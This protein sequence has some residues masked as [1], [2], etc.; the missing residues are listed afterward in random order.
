MFTPRTP[1]ILMLKRP[2]ESNHVQIAVRRRISLVRIAVALLALASPAATQLK[3]HQRAPQPSPPAR[4][5]SAFAYDAQ[6]AE[7]VLFGGRTSAA[8]LRDT[9][10]WNGTAWTQCQPVISPP[11]RCGHRVWGVK[12]FFPRP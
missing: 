8:Q 12:K 9:W 5:D 1:R 3:W 11:P 6:Q 4:S 7:T 2:I 10:A